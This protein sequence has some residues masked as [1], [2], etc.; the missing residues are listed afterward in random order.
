MLILASG[1]NRVCEKKIAKLVGEDIER[2]TPN[3]VKSATGF[4]I[5]GVPPFG[6]QS[7][8]QHIFFDETLLSFDQVWAAAGTPN[9][10]FDI[11]PTALV[12][13]TKSKVISLN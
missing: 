10:V 1:I 5:G 3:I 12:K 2:A 7:A 6:H 4:T 11:V 8:I 13:M 9:A